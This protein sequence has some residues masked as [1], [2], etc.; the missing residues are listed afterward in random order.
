MKSFEYTIKDELGI[1]ARPAGLLAKRA[2]EFESEITLTKGDRS[3]LC[4]RLLSLMSLGIKQ[5]DKVSITVVGVD[6]EA[7]AEAMKE[8]FENNL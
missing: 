7:A 1:H 6:E 4:S 5:G 8:F 2:K 3:A